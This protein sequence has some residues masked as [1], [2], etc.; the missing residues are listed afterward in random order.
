[1]S[2]TG[3][4]ITFSDGTVFRARESIDVS[5]GVQPLYVLDG[6][7]QF[8]TIY[9][10]YFDGG[11]TSGR[12]NSNMSG[13]FFGFGAGVHTITIGVYQ[14]EGNGQTWGNANTADGGD[15]ALNM[16]QRLNR[17]VTTIPNDSD[18]PITLE[19][20]EYS[21]SGIYDPL[22]VAII[23]CDLQ[24]KGATDD[25]EVGSFSGTIEFAET[26]NLTN[27]ISSTVRRN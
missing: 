16:L 13:L 21:T 27:P 19:V 6:F 8:I 2:L 11:G 25:N 26:V 12:A 4:K 15:T 17:A 9:N 20:G 7:R 3:F 22:D 23:S 18:D 10:E 1:M 5:H 24:Y 14:F